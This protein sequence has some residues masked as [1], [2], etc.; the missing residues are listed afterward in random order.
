[1]VRWLRIGLIVFLGMGSAEAA[2]RTLNTSAWTQDQKNMLEAIGYR[3]VF[4]AGEN[5]VPT[6]PDDATL[7]FANSTVDLNT[8]LT[9]SLVLTRYAANQQLA[10][11]ALA[12]DQVRQKSFQDEL[13]GTT[14]NDLCPADL[15]AITTKIDAVKASLDTEINNI[16]TLLNAKPVLLD[17]NAA[18]ATALKKVARCLRATRRGS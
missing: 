10:A 1:M 6:K 16:T 4:E 18:Y 14:G 5:I 17:L 9:E 12:V 8:V 3:L 2:C 11:D 7:C 13:D 15:T